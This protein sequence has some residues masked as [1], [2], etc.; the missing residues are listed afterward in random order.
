MY[1]FNLSQVL[2]AQIVPFQLKI[3]FKPISKYEIIFFVNF[4]AIL[5]FGIMLI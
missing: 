4:K 2:K 3:T 5:C 1:F